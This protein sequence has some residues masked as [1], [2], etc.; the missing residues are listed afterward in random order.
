MFHLGTKVL[1]GAVVLLSLP[2]FGTISAPAGTQL[3]LSPSSTLSASSLL[4]GGRIVYRSTPKGR[5]PW[6]VGVIAEA[7]LT[8]EKAL[9]WDVQDTFIGFNPGRGMPGFFLGRLHPFSVSGLDPAPWGLIAQS[10][11]LN[12]GLQYGYGFGPTSVASAPL[13]SGWVG[14]HMWNETGPLAYGASFSPVYIPPL[15][16]AF[17]TQVPRQALIE[18]QL[19]AL[20]TSVQFDVW[21]DV[22][23]LPQ[24]SLYAR[25]DWTPR[26]RSWLWLSRS[27]NPSP[28]ITA[29]GYLQLGDNDSSVVA[30][31][32]P[33]F[34]P[35]WQGG[36]SHCWRLGSKN[37]AKLRAT[38]L[39]QD[40]YWGTELALEYSYFSI[41]LAGQ[42]SD[43][44]NSFSNRLIRSEARIPLSE[45][46]SIWSSVKTHLGQS[47]LWLAAGADFQLSRET[48]LTVASD[49]FSGPENSYFG[50]NRSRDRVF[51]VLKWSSFD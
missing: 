11:T 10:Q 15:G 43:Q 12:T 26:H 47:D 39:Y 36:L 18:G 35:A 2:V 30:T 23:L 21:K 46:L 31:I 49:I 41:A 29:S 14:F 13:L 3:Y 40:R 50:V 19:V 27:P 34:R 32:S 20:K 37:A 51:M 4:A 7:E 5:Y 48:S 17:Q 16:S 8:G 42:N 25:M 22:L 44:G 24:S 6:R 9:L 28:D 33:R 38:I 1:L 45:V